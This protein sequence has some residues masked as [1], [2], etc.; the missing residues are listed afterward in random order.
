MLT[1]K[2][3]HIRVYWIYF[4]CPTIPFIA[5]ISDI[6][7]TMGILSDMNYNSLSRRYSIRLLKYLKYFYWKRVLCRV[8]TDNVKNSVIV[9]SCSNG[10]QNTLGFVFH[11]EKKG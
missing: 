6:I 3:K 7:P 5:F 4:C 1:K 9:F 8:E 11:G 2:T 10:Y